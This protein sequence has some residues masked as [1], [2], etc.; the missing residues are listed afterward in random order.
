MDNKEVLNVLFKCFYQ[1]A[2]KQQ[3]RRT[4]CCRIATG[5][6]SIPVLPEHLEN[7]GATLCKVTDRRDDW[8]RRNQLEFAPITMSVTKPVLNKINTITVDCSDAYEL[9]ENTYRG[10]FTI[11]EMAHI[12]N[13]YAS[14]QLIV[15]AVSCSMLVL[16]CSL[17]L[18]QNL[19]CSF[20]P[21][22]R[23]CR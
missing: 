7:G 9:F 11:A 4:S 16:S 23:V 15:A 20:F 10:N 17:Q 22:H 13:L 1:E 3:L 5:E 8:G 14:L 21:N 19:I 6:E 12:D 18:V 2:I